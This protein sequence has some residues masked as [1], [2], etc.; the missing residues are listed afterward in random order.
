MTLHRLL[1]R[2]LKRYIGSMDAL[3]PEWQR[4]I[5]AVN[6]AYTQADIDRQMVENSLELASQEL[7]E[8]NA[9][10]REDLVRRE[11]A[12]AALRESE[13]R[14][15][16][17]VDTA[18]D[19]HIAIDSQGVITNWSRQTE[20]MFG[21]RAD[22]AIGQRLSETIIPLR[23]R[24]AHE[25]GLRHFLETGEGPILN[26]RLEIEALHRDGHE[27]PIE[28]SIVP[29][30]AHDTYTF[31]AFV[32]DITARTEAEN[33]LRRQSAYL[34]ALHDT[35]V[36]L[37]G[38][39]ELQSLLEA[40]LVRAGQLIGTSHGFVSLI[41]PSGAVAEIKYAVGLFS[42]QLEVGVGLHRGEGLVGKVWESGQPLV[43]NHYDAWEGRPSNIPTGRFG[44]MMGAP[45]K[46]S[47]QIIGVIGMA[48]T[49]ESERAFSDDEVEV[50]SRFAQL[51]AVAID[52]AQAYAAAQ[53]E[54]AERKRAEAAVR[55]SE[56]RLRAI[57]EATPTPILIT[58]LRDAQVLYVNEATT[59]FFGLSSAEMLQRRSTD[60]YD[61]AENQKIL[62]ALRTQ[63]NVPSIELQVRRATGDTLW[64]I[65][66]MRRMKFNG[67]NATLTGFYDI[68]ALKQAEEKLAQ[69]LAVLR[70]T[71]DSTTDG[72][73]ALNQ[74]G[75][76]TQFNTK[77]AEVWN[78][79]P[80][81]LATRDNNQILAVMFRQLKHPDA[82]FST[83]IEMYE[84]PEAESFDL[85]EFQDG[86]I[87]ERYS[88]PQRI[89]GNIV[90]R[91]WSYRDI[92]E[93]RRYEAELQAAK[94]AAE[95][96][97][98]AK[99]E[100]LASMSHEIR[101]PMN[102]VI[103]MTSL[104]LDTSLTAEQRDFAETIRTSSDSLLTII[105]DILDFSKIEAGKLELEHQPFDLRDCIE[106]ALDLL[107]AKAAEK[108]LN[109]AYLIEP[110]VP[111]AFLG[112]VTRVR[113]ILVNLLSN[114]VKFT[115]QGEVVVSVSSVQES[116]EAHVKS[117]MA[118]DAVTEGASTLHFSVRDTG[119]G[120]PPERMDK[121][122]Q[123][124][125]QVDASTTRRYGGTGLGLVISKRLSEMMGGD[126]WAESAVGKGS[127]FH[128]TIQAKA[129]KQLMHTYAQGEQPQLKGK[130]LLIVDD[131]PTNR[132]IVTLQAQAWRMDVRAAHSAAEALTWI[133]RGEPFD[134]A[135]LDM[136][137]PDMDGVMLAQEIRKVERLAKVT[138][139]SQGL[140][141]LI[142]L[143]SLG[144]RVED[145][146]AADFVAFLTKPIKAS[147]L[148]NALL[149]AFVPQP[150]QPTTIRQFDTQLGQRIPLR[151]LVAEDN[152]INQK[153]ALTLLQRMGYRADV[154]ANGLEVLTALQRQAYD[155]VL[156]D[157]QM[158][159][160]DGLET[161]RRIR[162]D[163]VP[164]LL[165]QPIIIAMTANA[166]QG[167]REA[168][169]A[170][171]MDDYLSKP[172]QVKALQGA[173]EHWGPRV[174][175]KD[176]V[177]RMPMSSIATS[178]GITPLL[179]NPLNHAMVN[180]LREELG[181][182][183]LR[184][185]VGLYRKEARKQ[186]ANLRSVIGKNDAKQL[187]AVAHSFKGS[188][189]N[190][191]AQT[192]MELAAKLELLGR[193]GVL[194]GAEALLAQIEKEVE[195]VEQAFEQE[196]L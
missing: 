72:I 3:Q 162:A 63:R 94:E 65:A 60:F 161:S 179:P 120:I 97:N 35:T 84:H 164:L 28:L 14:T 196:Q 178:G 182:D 92:T 11:Q 75:I 100:F 31:S 49:R 191:G 113:Q 136:Q 89:G 54:L 38:H 119:I 151:I 107:A 114:A 53:Q 33:T 79:S 91:V 126:I 26:Q 73:M 22:E 159:E 64:V 188:S 185:I 21:W 30:R 140:L 139:P 1:E 57:A 5:E 174:R 170:A 155:V 12:E 99:S 157:V 192:V 34:S 145:A 111:Q 51:A 42:E 168:C 129:T 19:A 46:V 130:R 128:F 123:S 109:L 70:A 176:R 117:P 25:R 115:E 69:S 177:N 55:E 81:I 23:Y 47:E 142:M 6:E 68:T 195:R 4:F 9:R 71:L 184:E 149:S 17:I 62:D 45:L 189:G 8:R 27:F 134:V 137:M 78:I 160:L 183:D 52:N 66:S 85:I 58:R 163:S 152:A 175:D 39:H 32:R 90:G 13:T 77:F 74:E 193:K 124:F 132:R 112:D 138:K 29:L 121:L 41:E 110:H 165:Q 154:A 108:H 131:N 148:Y 18:L 96:A 37:L 40:I 194:D 172:I 24:A 43:V 186:I 98:R 169:L 171:G 16:L 147:Q 167:D 102:A 141:P 61:E 82:H 158:P 150:M 59:P 122:F 106:S 143:T 146:A 80:A 95:A 101:T 86:R 15:R 83:L 7:L 187:T 2:Q 20:T 190:I 127:T 181:E 48:Y 44:A 87:V 166:M 36:G 144:W 116:S 125:T 180:T 135:I 104:L 133:H 10:L 76:I 93:R 153:L 50:L 156:M 88:K 105:N 173:L 56:E 67:E 103:G 118:H